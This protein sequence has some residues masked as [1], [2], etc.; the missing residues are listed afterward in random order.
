MSTT[1]QSP[2]EAE[3]APIVK[4]SP[5]LSARE[6]KSAAKRKKPASVAPKGTSTNRFTACSSAV[7]SDRPKSDSAPTFVKEMVGWG[8]GPRA[9]ISLVAAAKSYA[10]LRGRFHAT[11][12]DVA[13]VALPVLRHRILTTFN[14]EAAGITSDEII[15]MLLQ[16][17]APKE[18]LEI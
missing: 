6:A 4:A 15:R 3:I 2:R 17:L 7:N 8:A 10:V 14:A 18:D 16:E 1:Y 11:T 13:A 9:G 12:G 5:A